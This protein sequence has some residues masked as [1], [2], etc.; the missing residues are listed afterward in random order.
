LFYNK[1]GTNDDSTLPL[2][3][4]FP[5]GSVVLPPEDDGRYQPQNRAIQF[6]NILNTTAFKHIS[7][8]FTP[9]LWRRWMTAFV[10]TQGQLW[11]DN[12]QSLSDLV[13]ASF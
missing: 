13:E 4:I 3:I 7:R 9:V 2:A 8:F 10:K 12:S 1:S 5:F 11:V 6:L